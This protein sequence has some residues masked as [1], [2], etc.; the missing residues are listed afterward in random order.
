VEGV[1]GAVMPVVGA[2]DVPVLVDELAALA[3]AAPPP[4]RAPVTARLVS[5]GLI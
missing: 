5:S 1:V 3:I 4:T 2:V